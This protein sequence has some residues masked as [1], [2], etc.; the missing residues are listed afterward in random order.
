MALPKDF[1]ETARQRFNDAKEHSATWRSEARDDY[2]FVS[3]DQWEPDDENV[4]EEQN[5][6]K[7]TFNYSE[8]MIDAVVGAE[9]NSRQEIRYFPRE[10]NDGALAE[11]WSGAAKW[12]R[13]QCNAEDEETDAF[14]DS[15]I[16][17]MGWAETYISYD[18]DLDGMIM[19]ERIDPLEMYWDP[20]ARKYGLTDRRYDFREMWVDEKELQRKYPGKLV[21]GVDTMPSGGIDRITAGRRYNDDDLREAAMHEGQIN[22][23]QYECWYMGSVYRIAD[24]EQG[25][26]IEVSAEQFKEQKDAIEFYGL[27]YVKQE[28]RVYYQ[29]LF[30]GETMLEAKVSPVQCGFTRNAITG[31]RDRNRNQWYGLTK[32][33][34]DPQRWANKWLSQ[35][36]HIINAN[37]KGGILAEVGAFVDPRRAQE[38][39]AQADSVT[40]LKEG[41]IQKIKEKTA[42][43]YP[44][45]IDRLMEFALNSL[46]QVTG[47]NL[48]ALGLAGREQAGILEQERKQAAYGLLAPAFNALRTYRKNAGR[49]LLYYI[50]EYIADGRMIRLTGPEGQQTIPLTKDKQSITYDIIIDQAPDSPDSK[51][52]TWETLQTILPAM[53]KANI[54]IPPDLF[55]Y[56]PLPTA[57]SQKWKQYAA[58]QQ[59]NIS[60]E[61]MQQVQQKMQQLMEENQSLKMD[62]GKDMAEFQMKAQVAKG[63]HQM[64]VERMNR[65]FQ[66]KQIE[67]ER[68]FA[69]KVQELQMEYELKMAQFTQESQLDATKMQHDMMCKRDQLNGDLKIKAMQAGVQ[70]SEGAEGEAPELSLKLDISDLSNALTQI[71]QGN[72]EVAAAQASTQEAIR[73]MTE[74]LSAPKEVIFKDGRPVGIKPVK[75]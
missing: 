59:Q 17:G 40:L 11:L 33:M 63:E 4:L 74:Q 28:K 20:A 6:P 53:M 15:L 48:E 13:D 38:E 25:G 64:E 8:K 42:G 50:Q 66:L 23:L 7:V 14:R 65:E 56:T 45:G 12:A 35:I 51:T 73:A 22:V 46:P 75:G 5:R 57:L 31:K 9:I 70:A 61:Q 3:G 29:A 44:S 19:T 71:A 67:M 36:M 37:A 16:C 41:G 49:V 1:E 24:P 52:K 39:W 27:Q 43:N 10:V 54:P 30:A 62:Q 32:V 2:A 47:I 72:L 18:H 34:K 68:T 58:Q 55:D 60:P 26:I 69:L 21:T